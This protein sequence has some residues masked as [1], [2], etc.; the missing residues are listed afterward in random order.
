MNQF[1]ALVLAAGKSS[2]FKTE[3]SKLAYPICGQELINYPIKVLLE[4]NL[5]VTCIIGHKKNEIQDIIKKSTSH[6]ITYQ[7][8]IEQRGTGHAVLCALHLLESEHI[9]IINGDMPLIT[10]ELITTLCKHHKE[11]QATISFIVSH[12]PPSLDHGY[13]RVVLNNG[14]IT[15]IEAR[16]YNKHENINHPI[17]AGI[18]CIQRAFL[19]DALQKLVPNSITSELYITDLIHIATQNNERVEMLEAPYEKIQGVNTLQELAAVTRI[20]QQEIIDHWMRNGVYCR[21]P[22]A[23]YIDTQASIESGAV[24]EAGVHIL[25]NSTIRNNCTIGAY[26]YINNSTLAENVT[27]Y[28]YTIISDS[29]INGDAHIGPYAHVQKSIVDSQARIGNFVETNR[30]MIGQASKAKHLSY[31]GD[32]TLG[33]SVNIGAGTITCNYD[34]F[35]KHPTIIKDHAF[36]GSNNALIAPITIGNSA[37]TGA[38]SVITEDVPA[39]ALAIGRARQVIKENYTQIDQKIF[40][41]AQT[42]SDFTTE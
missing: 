18:Y 25:G 19:Q 13:G 20:K 12:V 23:L 10:A 26:S 9:L 22:Q 38:G 34:G 14:C 41:A 31:L 4:C 35:K 6:S 30:T 28:P 1:Q 33:A 17:N 21:D 24:L 2:R 42:S 7:E 5:P 29:I 8:Q 27:V 16:N 37:V 15:I 40:A 3:K 32:S 39:Y 11:Q 36:I